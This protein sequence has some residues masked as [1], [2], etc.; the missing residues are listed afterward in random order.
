MYLARYVIVIQKPIVFLYTVSE[1]SENEIK[2]QVHL[3]DTIEKN[4]ILKIIFNQ[5]STIFVN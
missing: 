2:K 5:G 1:K 4:K 3:T